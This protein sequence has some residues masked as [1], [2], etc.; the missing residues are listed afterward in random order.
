M[1]LVKICIIIFS[2][3]IIFGCTE[4][5]TYSGKIITQESVGEELDYDPSEGQDWNWED[6]D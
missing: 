5:T 2:V 3:N 6:Y 4:K 1:N